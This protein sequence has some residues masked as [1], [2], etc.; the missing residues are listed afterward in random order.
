MPHQNVTKFPALKL[1]AVLLEDNEWAVVSSDEAKPLTKEQAEQVAEAY[2]ALVHF[3][4]EMKGIDT[5]KEY[6]NFTS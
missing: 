1:A 6:A 3:E 5:K 2:V 4:A